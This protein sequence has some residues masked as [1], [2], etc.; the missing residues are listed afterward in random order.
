MTLGLIVR[1]EAEQDI[2]DAYIWYEERLNGLGEQFI[3]AVDEGMLL[4]SREPEIFQKVYRSLRRALIHRFPYGIF[5][6]IEPSGIVVLAVMHTSRL[7]SK[8][9]QRAKG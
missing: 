4:V 1:P 9:K 2:K 8:W 3:A 5:Y 7:P 6:T